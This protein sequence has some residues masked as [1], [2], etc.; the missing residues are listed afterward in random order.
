MT[1]EKTFNYQQAIEKI[2]AI[3]N[4]IE[5][6]D[7][8]VDDLTKMVNEAFELIK[9]CKQKLNISEELLNTGFEKSETGN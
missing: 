1:R 6:G 3:L 4:E 2:E 8:N 7:P 5:N 9:Q